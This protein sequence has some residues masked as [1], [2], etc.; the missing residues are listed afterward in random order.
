MILSTVLTGTRF[1]RI[2]IATVGF[3]CSTLVR[4]VPGQ[5]MDELINHRKSDPCQGALVG[6]CDKPLKF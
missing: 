2:A 6:R 4:V 1:Q 5:V 3:Q